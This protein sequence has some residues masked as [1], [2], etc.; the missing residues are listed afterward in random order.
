MTVEEIL[1]LLRS[2]KEDY[3]DPGG[4]MEESWYI[5]CAAKVNVLEDMIY[6]IESRMKE[7]K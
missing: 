1:E 3:E 5:K 2:T 7:V 6:A 4:Y